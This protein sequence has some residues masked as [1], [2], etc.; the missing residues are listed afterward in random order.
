M[1]RTRSG[2]KSV[3]F[4]PQIR[5]YWS[6]NFYFGLHRSC[7]HKTWAIQSSLSDFFCVSFI[8]KL[9]C[10]SPS[11]CIQTKPVEF[12]VKSGSSVALQRGEDVSISLQTR[13]QPALGDSCRLRIIN[14]SKCF[15]SSHHPTYLQDKKARTIAH[16]QFMK[17]LFIF[18]PRRLNS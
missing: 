3:L 18:L 7:Q 13:E 11:S 4:R 9:S 17:Q 1:G 14:L 10:L 2:S 15:Y 8:S 5:N 12:L 16:C 6:L